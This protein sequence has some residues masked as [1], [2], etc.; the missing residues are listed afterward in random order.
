MKN[1][2]LNIT[3][4]IQRQTQPLNF[5]LQ[6]YTAPIVITSSHIQNVQR[7]MSLIRREEDIPSDIENYVDEYHGTID[8]PEHPRFGH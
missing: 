8:I 1:T 5:G 3:N 2:L 6:T 4:E 7:I